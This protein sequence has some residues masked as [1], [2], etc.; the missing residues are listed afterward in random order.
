MKKIILPTLLLLLAIS[1]NAQVVINE[2][3]A[4]SDS[5]SNLPDEYGEY[6]DW[7]ELYN[8]SSSDFALG[9]YHISDDSTE[10]LKW[11]IPAGT[12]VP[13]NGYL[14]IWTDKDENNGQVPLHTNFKLSSGGE[15]VLLSNS[16]GAYVDSIAFGPQVTN[17]TFARIPNGTGNFTDWNPSFGF[18]ND[19]VSSTNNLNLGKFL[20]YPN[21]S[22]DI[23]NIQFDE[24]PEPELQLEIINLSGQVFHTESIKDYKALI[25]INQLG[26][27]TYFLKLTAGKNTLLRPFHKL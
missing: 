13:G 22:T 5:L 21:P 14:I 16:T 26:K 6:D 3:M 24:L 9:G 12:T 20:L 23:I 10:P 17:R 18:S 1:V 2:L 25:N 7:V 15:T 11:E 19:D 8:S 4:S 27:G